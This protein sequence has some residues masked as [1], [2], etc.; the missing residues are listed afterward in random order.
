MRC[1]LLAKVVISSAFSLNRAVPEP[2][3]KSPGLLRKEKDDAEKSADR[4]S[5]TMNA[6]IDTT[7]TISSDAHQ[8][9]SELGLIALHQTNEQSTLAARGRSSADPNVD[10]EFADWQDWSLCSQ[11]CGSGMASRTREVR[12]YAQGNGS[13]CE[14]NNYEKRECSRSVCPRDCELREW[15]DWQSC[16]VS[17]GEG[18]RY[19][20]RRTI[21][22][23]YGGAECLQP[24]Q[25]S[26]AC[27]VKPCPPKCA[28]NSW[29]EWAGCTVTC[30]GAQEK[31]TRTLPEA[32]A[33]EDCKGR[34]EESRECSQH[35]CPVDCQVGDWEPWDP[36][37]R[38][39]GEGTTQR[40]RE[41]TR[42]MSWGGAPC[43]KLREGKSCEVI[44]CPRD[45]LWSTWSD[46]T[47]CS[48]SCGDNGT[49]V[50]NRAI[51]QNSSSLGENCTGN[52]SQESPCSRHPCP[53]NCQISAWTD[54]SSCSVSCGSGGTSER[55]RNIT[56]AQ[57]GGTEC[58]ENS[59]FQKRSC[60]LPICPEDCMW[61]DWQD[62]SACSVTCG[63]G[64]GSRKRMIRRSA[65]NGGRECLGSDAQT[66]SCDLAICPIHCKW[67]DWSSW[68]P[69]SVTCGTGGTQNRN[70]TISVQAEF[71]GDPCTGNT[72]QE[73]SCSASP[74][75][76][77][78][79][80]QDWQ[81][82][83]SCSSSCG[84]GNLKRFRSSSGP[85]YGGRRC[86]GEANETTI[87]ENLPACPVDCLWTDWSD[88]G[89][90]SKTCGH[91]VLQRTRNRQIQE[92]YGGH[93]CYGTEDDEQECQLPPCPV[94]G[95]VG[96]W[97]SW[98]GCS[99][100]CGNG[101]TARSR[102]TIQESLYG[103]RSVGALQES[104]S[105][106]EE[107]CPIDCE[108]SQWAS[109]T[110]CSRSCNGGKTSRSRTISIE[111]N[112]LGRLCK[113]GLF[114]ETICN[115][116]L[117]PVDCEWGSWSD[118]SGCSKS[119]GR[120][121]RIATRNVMQQMSAGG[122]VCKGSNSKVDSCNEWD[123][124]VDC[125]WDSWSQWSICTRHCGTGVTQRMRNTSR[126][127]HNGGHPCS[128]PAQEENSCNV[129]PCPVP[130]RWGQWSPW[131]PCSRTCGG[132]STNRVR[133]VTQ[134]AQYGG[135]ECV[136]P[137]KQVVDCNHDECLPNPI[138]CVWQDWSVWSNC[139]ASCGGGITKRPRAVKIMSQYGG[140]ACDGDSMQQNKCNEVPCPLDCVL[141]DWKDWSDCSVSCGVGSRVRIRVR[142][143]PSYGGKDCDDT[144]QESEECANSHPDCPNANISKLSTTTSTV[145]IAS[146]DSWHYVV[147]G[148]ALRDGV[149]GPKKGSECRPDVVNTST[150]R[151]D[152]GD[153]LGVT[154]CSS[155]GRGYRP[156][157]VSGK[158]YWEAEALCES[159]GLRLCTKKEILEGKGKG[160][161]CGFDALSHWVSDECVDGSS[162]MDTDQSYSAAVPSNVAS[163]SV[164][165]MAADAAEKF[166]SMSN[167]AGMTVERLIDAV[168]RPSSAASL[169]ALPN[170]SW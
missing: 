70:R 95:I 15:Q 160:S 28:Y 16:T 61:N 140:A 56:P 105:C 142:Q 98:S 166:A 62:W 67:S 14:F 111:G 18:L 34:L 106:R 41:V 35:E 97:S 1:A 42:Q 102:K 132:G 104:K 146:Q 115:V 143:N 117:C 10:C 149:W 93:V 100:T 36:C 3:T 96:D 139:T 53:A 87:C 63:L 55:S 133:P 72:S 22:A 4:T 119:C 116:E 57:F 19:R 51:L 169:L 159:K 131:S 154:C 134:E 12:R 37:S 52:A 76:V 23:M 60:D 81:A 27:P 44:A 148:D 165:E 9:A 40:T 152:H 112:R 130:C 25:S 163:S 30:G 54:W 150:V 135:D 5:S 66:R 29:G 69:C 65:A 11:S 6:V 110:T 79:V 7:G 128:G 91:G 108:Y 43:G 170:I 20:N 31:R 24:L 73:Q 77:D 32:A 21:A 50:R 39:C 141:M 126:V 85:E 129:D 74:C 124:P 38:S 151:N 13:S 64:Q 113:G 161:G 103:G 86:E 46:W 145:P 58:T 120:G 118:W 147:I 136:G 162:G 94:D 99:V 138:E 167:A 26:E 127:E 8:Q 89:G 83:G 80:W 48:V 107:V 153:A 90:C 168:S 84:S 82:W 156:D 78:C 123:C 88:W 49:S 122:Q 2:A 101:T 45:C 137:L 125:I 144:L 158:A 33:N 71:N 92:A 109:W 75:P 155:D 59:V 47:S 17:C 164:R 68:D 121:Q 114:E 157:C